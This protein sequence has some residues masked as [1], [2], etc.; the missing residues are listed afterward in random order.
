MGGRVMVGLVILAAASACATITARVP[1][2]GPSVT[3]LIG[4]WEGVYS[5]RETGRS[6]TIL[7]RLHALAD[8]AQGTVFMESKPSDD[9]ANT[10]VVRVPE[11]A[12]TPAATPLYIRFVVVRDLEVRG[13]LEPY[14]DPQCGCLLKT[15]FIG[16][17]DG[18]V[19]EGT[20]K[21]EGEG[22]HHLP[23]SGEWRVKRV[24]R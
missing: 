4:D 12:R 14:R 9:P 6:G 17:I 16:R 20:F 15:E 8:T 19:I 24:S 7:F 13:V 21:S 5:S 11:S 3:E 2:E 23:A 1:V 18:D 22:F 10:G